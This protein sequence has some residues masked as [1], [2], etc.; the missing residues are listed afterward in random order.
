LCFDLKNSYKN[1]DTLG[2][3]HRIRLGIRA[4]LLSTASRPPASGA[5]HHANM[6]TW[7]DRADRS[8]QD[9]LGRTTRVFLKRG[10]KETNDVVV[11]LHEHLIGR[12]SPR[13]WAS[14]GYRGTPWQECHPCKHLIH[15]DEHACAFSV[16]KRPV[17]AQT[18]QAP[19]KQ[20]SQK[21]QRPWYP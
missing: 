14:L 2:P 11:K 10:Q 7:F 15:Q 8:T 16:W 21:R 17:K 12:T 18:A 4:L 5:S 9:C 1:C 19:E 13:R 3:S 6:S 20:W